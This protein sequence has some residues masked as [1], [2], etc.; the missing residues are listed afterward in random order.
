[1]K[2]L[3]ESDYDGPRHFDAHA[4]RTEDAEGVWDFARG[5]MRTY[6]ILKEKARQFCVDKEI[7]ALL[8]EIRGFR[9]QPEESDFGAYSRR[10]A[11]QLKAQ[12][13]D[14]QALASR[15][16]PYEKLD[17]LLVDLLLGVR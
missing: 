9:L 3:E 1:M 4:Y 6:L 11:D 14:R 7:Q 13:F 10:A 5:C 12:S 15:R 8:A 16:L 2:L 17:Q